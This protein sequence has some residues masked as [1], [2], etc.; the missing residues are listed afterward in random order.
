MKPGDL[1]QF[2]EPEI[3][4]TDI[5]TYDDYLRL[6]KLLRE[7]NYTNESADVFYRKLANKILSP[8]ETRNKAP[9][10]SIYDIEMVR[11]YGNERKAKLLELGAGTGL[12]TN[13]LSGYF[14]KI[15]AVEKYKE[16]AKFIKAERNVHIIVEDLLELSKNQDFKRHKPEDYSFDVSNS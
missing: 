1:V 8:L 4:G 5:D 7:W 12:M 9:D 11:A 14:S 6:P 2:I 3:N 15:V 13:E 10:F 16:F